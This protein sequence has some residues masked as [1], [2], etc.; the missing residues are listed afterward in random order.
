[1]YDFETKKQQENDS[2]FNSANNEKTVQ[3]KEYS[4]VNYLKSAPVQKKAENNTGLPDNLKSGIENMSGYS[5]D[6]V[7]VH[8][9]SSKPAQM[10]A[11]AYTQGSDIHVAPGQE[12][13]L[14][15]EAWH[16]VQQ[17]QGRVAPTTQMKG[18]NVND[19]PALEHEADVM[20]NKAT[21][22][23]AANTRDI[24]QY[25][26]TKP[27]NFNSVQLKDAGKAETEAETEAKTEAETEAKKYFFEVDEKTLNESFLTKDEKDD[28][29]K[30]RAKVP[31]DS[32]RR[33]N[34]LKKKLRKTYSFKAYEKLFEKI[35]NIHKNIKKPD[36]VE[37]NIWESIKN[38]FFTQKNIHTIIGKTFSAS[39]G[40]DLISAI[41]IYSNMKKNY[42]E[43]AKSVVNDLEITISQTLSD[44][45]YWSCEYKHGE[46]SEIQLTDSDVHA[47]GVGVCIVTF[48]DSNNK[49]VIKPEDKSLEKAIYGKDNSLAEDFN[50][51]KYDGDKKTEYNG[52]NTLNI[53]A[54]NDHGSA[55]EFFEHDDISKENTID[56]NNDNQTD[57]ESIKDI[58]EFASLLGLRDLH[59]EN[60][61]Y[62]KADKSNKRKMQLIDAEIAL[63][64]VLDKDNPLASAWD[65]EINGRLKTFANN[66]MPISTNGKIS[67][68]ANEF[69]PEDI[70]H[71]L[72][73]YSIQDIEQSLKF[74]DKV[75]DKFKGKKS[76]VV[77]IDT[78]TLY[79]FRNIAYNNGFKKE[80]TVDGSREGFI[81]TIAT[82]NTF[83]TLK[84][85]AGGTLNIVGE[86]KI[87]I[88]TNSDFLKGR[89][90]FWE[91]DFDNGA[92]IQKFSNGESIIAINNNLKLDKI[93][94]AR[95]KVLQKSINLF[96]AATPS[97]NDTKRNLIGRYRNPNFIRHHDDSIENPVQKK[98]NLAA[99]YLK[100]SPIQKKNDFQKITPSK[101]D[102]K[103]NLIGS[104]RNSKDD[105]I[106]F[107][108]AMFKRRKDISWMKKEKSGMAQKQLKVY[109]KY[110]EKESESLVVDSKRID[111]LQNQL[112]NLSM[113]FEYSNS[114]DTKAKIKEHT[115]EIF[116]NIMWIENKIRKTDNSPVSYNQIKRSKILATEILRK[117][118]DR[119]EENTEVRKDILKSLDK[120]RTMKEQTKSADV[121]EGKK[122]E[123]YKH[124]EKF[125]RNYNDS[126]IRKESDPI[127]KK[128]LIAYMSYL[129]KES[130]KRYDL[131]KDRVESLY[132]QL[133][134]LRMAYENSKSD[135]V[136]YYIA[137]EVEK[138]SEN[139]NW[140]QNQLKELSDRVEIS[141]K[142][143]EYLRK[144]THDVIFGQPY[145]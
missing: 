37:T 42:K 29:Y 144:M 109:M 49:L 125:R 87:I 126:I 112:S 116:D 114:S 56:N 102:T 105:I 121:T 74:M 69:K 86:D 122:L 24:I 10:K 117:S 132:N 76:R 94:E 93:I 141:D 63:A 16:V 118:V 67:L 50:K 36:Y 127:A 23:K 11:L 30:Y 48:K 138:I 3:K 2:N 70:R 43:I 115:A 46:V 32:K 9:N 39:T 100:S 145:L 17:K 33:H 91:Y 4:A 130:I 45:A 15:H 137:D 34:I 40:A 14:G 41:S 61:V 62:S 27:V 97:K 28:Y 22:F 8:Y 110:L 131:D 82:S 18:V 104:Y 21:Q 52:V 64:N 95:K 80:A 47:R 107:D 73:T 78:G 55:V 106:V 129:K 31:K 135:D 75:K 13:H 143:I 81:N 83:K 119:N 44:I 111:V 65:S 142:D 96:Q 139:L 136:Q 38:T 120:H 79:K 123:K 12:Q 84:E 19:N 108:E 128:Q 51:I 26:M 77:L 35:S 99:N 20:G 103:R 140:M 1:M 60:L 57:R 133:K 88:R 89:I 101:S 90:P 58:I 59:H 6:D 5:M 134:N 113:A 68:N 72:L 71:S 92:I 66:I 7:K 54:T 85:I 98:E 25:K 124:I 53:N